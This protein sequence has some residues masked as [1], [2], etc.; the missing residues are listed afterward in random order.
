M[1]G[2]RGYHY[3]IHARC[4]TIKYPEARAL[5]K[6]TGRAIGMFIFEELLCRWGCIPEIVSDNGS[7]I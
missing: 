6:E 3:I 5:K 2:S 4:G 7:V 1:P